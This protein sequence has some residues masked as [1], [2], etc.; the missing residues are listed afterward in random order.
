[1]L[2]RIIFLLLF[3]FSSLSAYSLQ[4]YLSLMKNHP[5][6]GPLGSSKEGEIE[7]VL[8]PSE[9]LKIEKIAKE[10]LVK[11]GVP[12]EKATS[13]SRV[14]IIAEDQYLYLLRDAVIFPKGGKGTYDR[15]VWKN[16]LDGVTGAAI[17]P[18]LPN[19]EILLNL[20]YRHATRSWELELPRGGRKTGQSPQ[21]AATCELKEETGLEVDEL[22]YLGEMCPDSG[23][24]S[25]RVAVFL[26]YTSKRSSAK[27][28]EGEAIAAHPTFTIE[29]LKNLISEGSFKT[30]LQGKEITVSVS[31]PFLTFALLQLKEGSLQKKEK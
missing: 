12:E 28:E 6:L 4:D 30:N 26:A 16:S 24:L 27:I 29:K 15:V 8:E 3:F 31:D 1:M 19:G 11:K 7:I 13:W 21:E 2:N 23:I 14:G 5:A 10:K 9:I 20:N 25:S 17:L 18:L 22:V